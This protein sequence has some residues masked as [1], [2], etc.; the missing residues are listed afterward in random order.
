MFI[1]LVVKC[2]KYD[3]KNLKSTVTNAVKSNASDV[4]K[5]VYVC[6]RAEVVDV[7]SRDAY[8]YLEIEEMMQSR[9]TEHDYYDSKVY[10]YGEAEEVKEDIALEK[11]RGED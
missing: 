4:F 5:K 7:I 1:S 3:W 9:F 6:N 8:A 2:S 11:R 10:Y